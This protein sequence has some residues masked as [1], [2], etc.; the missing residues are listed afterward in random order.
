MRKEI[1]SVPGV[2]NGEI[3]QSLAELRK[4]P[5]KT[6]REK[7]SAGSLLQFGVRRVH[8]L[9]MYSSEKGR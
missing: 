2:T 3:G 1:A 9:R 5:A 4:L 7:L 6:L 8:S